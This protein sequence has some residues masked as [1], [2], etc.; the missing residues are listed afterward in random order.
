[1]PLKL[2]DVNKFLQGKKEVTNPR[3]FNNNME[4]EPTGLQSP[5]IF[6]N[7]PREKF[8]TW[9]VI[10]LEDV[11]IHPFIYDNLNIIDPIFKRVLSKKSNVVIR[12]GKLT[13]VKEN[14][15]TGL[16]WLIANWDKINLDK[17]K[18]E[19]N[20]LFIE[21]LN[22]TNKNLLFINKVPVIPIAYREA[23]LGSF[24]IEL[25]ELDEIYQKLIGLSKSSRTDFTS[26][27][28]EAM[29]DV[30]SK[31]LIQNKV[32]QL[33]NY[34]IQKLE[35]K[36]GF[37]RGALTSKR[38]DNVARMVANA[39]PDIPVNCAVIPWHILLNLYDIFVV[40]FLKNDEK[41]GGE[42]LQKLGITAEKTLED[43]G[44]MFDYIYR[45][46][47][48]YEQHNPGKKEIWIE[49]L[50]NIFNENPKLRILLKRDPGWNADSFHC[51]APLINTENSYQVWTPSWV[52]SPLGGDSLSTNF[53]ICEEV[54]NTVYEDEEYIIKSAN[55]KKFT[56]KTMDSLWKSLVRKNT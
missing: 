25:S 21:F 36:H 46:A 26:E 50:T 13:E 39:R 32:N 8:E 43:Y 28:M 19:K 23:H 54:S 18:T 3:P 17:Y 12:D 37:V 53:F 51:F 4:P 34:F 41:A 6:G 55:K 15:N 7:T 31:E 52:Y 48:T 42:Y 20:K 2:L 47:A 45:N 5:V 33:F 35:G 22:N 10:N 11:I 1:M 49:I 16:S 29:K 44:H 30:N 38:L 14:G 24:K 56:V 40:A 27:W 9:G